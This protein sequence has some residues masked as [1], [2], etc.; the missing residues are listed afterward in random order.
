MEWG[1]HEGN[2][3]RPQDGRKNGLV[4]DI[5]IIV[6]CKCGKAHADCGGLVFPC[7]APAPAKE[8]NK[9]SSSAVKTRVVVTPTCMPIRI[10][11]NMSL[12]GMFLPQQ[13]T[14]KLP[15]RKNV[16]PQGRPEPSFSDVSQI[17]N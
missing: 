9:S 11:Q 14:M 1:S 13:H 4:G 16:Y 3:L 17:Q 7:K 15:Q 5:C 6:K 10:L 8:Q 2:V 12:E